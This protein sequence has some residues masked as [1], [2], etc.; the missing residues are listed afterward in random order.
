MDA[1]ARVKSRSAPRSHPRADIPSAMAVSLHPPLLGLP[2]DTDPI[3]GA[4]P[5]HELQAGRSV[6]H[7]N[8]HQSPGLRR[9]AERTA[10]G[11]GIPK[12]K[13]RGETIRKKVFLPCTIH[14]TLWLT[15]H[16]MGPT[17]LS[18]NILNQLTLKHNYL[19]ES[20]WAQLWKRQIETKG[21]RVKMLLN[22]PC[23]RHTKA[24]MLETYLLSDTYILTRQ[25]TFISHCLKSYLQLWLIF[26][27]TDR[28]IM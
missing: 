10:M 21:P 22:K 11:Q 1:V 12:I 20:A 27:R 19:A 26:H 14:K 2:L 28:L 16:S 25:N 6:T 9:A 23:H 5:N 24:L 4:P 13:T 3:W 15:L 17:Y 7:W 8:S 18:L